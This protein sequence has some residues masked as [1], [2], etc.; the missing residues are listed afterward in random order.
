M[1]YFTDKIVEA[2]KSQ[3]Y[4]LRR[5]S[6]ES[7]VS[8][9][10]IREILAGKIPSNT[11]IAKLCPPLGLQLKAMLRLAD[12]ERAET[13][14]VRMVYESEPHYRV[15]EA[16]PGYEIT[17]PPIQIPVIAHVS[18]G[19]PFQWTDGGYPAGAGLDYLD[20][21]PGVDPGLAHR[22]YALKV[23]GDSMRPFLK[24]G[25]VLIIDPGNR[26]SITHED[27]VIFKDSDYHA[28]VKM[29]EFHQGKIV[30]RSLN[31]MY[32]A[33]EFTPEQEVLMEP[34]YAI[35]RR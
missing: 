20:L 29:V 31:P 22:L 34:V 26:Q 3:G 32:P 4:S 11:V 10:Y 2:K 7:G 27:L 21:P 14:E 19:E 9:Q 12:I 25:A 1:S 30:L 35:I 8:F 17:D 15:S 23:R 16:T 24:D 33:L 13:D 28:W 6:A 18:A 5:L